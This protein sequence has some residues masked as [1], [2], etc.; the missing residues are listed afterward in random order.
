MPDALSKRFDGSFPVRDGSVRDILD[1]CDA[2]HEEYEA[3]IA[4]KH[5]PEWD[6]LQEWKLLKNQILWD[7]YNAIVAISHPVSISGRK[8]RAARQAHEAMMIQNGQ[9][10][11]RDGPYRAPVQSR[12][13]GPFG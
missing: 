8:F 5:R 2:N 7:R 3:W 1:L 11:A 9:H 10:W 12:R 6:K 13:A 4:E